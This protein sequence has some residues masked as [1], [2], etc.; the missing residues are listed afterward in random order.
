MVHDIKCESMDWISVAQLM[1][2]LRNLLT[3][4][5]CLFYF[6]NGGKFL[7]RWGA[8]DSKQLCLTRQT[9]QVPLHR[10]KCWRQPIQFT[11]L[12][13]FLYY[14]F[15]LK[16]KKMGKRRNLSGSKLSLT[17]FHCNTAEVE[18]VTQDM[19]VYCRADKCLW[20]KTTSNRHITWQ[21]KRK[22]ASLA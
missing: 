16:D 3:T 8:T 17:L 1:C 20:L 12:C 21:N 15:S 5:I 18:T 22:S 4:Q 13:N 11:T 9:E 6:R 14:F 19:W 7:I 2:V 10:R